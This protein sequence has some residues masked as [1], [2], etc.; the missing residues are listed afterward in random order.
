MTSR[1]DKLLKHLQK[2]L[3]DKAE[4]QLASEGEAEAKGTLISVDKILHELHVHQIELEM[5]NEELRKAQIELEATRDRYIDLYDFAPV[6]YLTIDGQGMIDDCNLTAAHLLGRER[7]EL[8][9]QPFVQFITE[10]EREAWSLHCSQHTLPG[11]KKL[12]SWS[13]PA[14]MASRSRFF[15]KACACKAKDRLRSGVSRSPTSLSESRPSKPCA[16]PPWL[17]KRRKASS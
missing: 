11:L 5:Q 9:R 4:A 13:F 16:L 2:Q 3:R 14:P 17:L 15:S 8:I 6:G 12:T 7:M 1:S 10:E